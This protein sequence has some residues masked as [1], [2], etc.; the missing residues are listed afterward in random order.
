M[1]HEPESYI[2]QNNQSMPDAFYEHTAT[3][4][5][6]YQSKNEK[7]PEPIKPVSLEEE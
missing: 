4:K 2:D 6:F 7:I 1:I 3:Q 5:L